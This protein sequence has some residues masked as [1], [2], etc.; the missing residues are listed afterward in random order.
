[1]FSIV[2]SF[3]FSFLF[4]Y[5]IV[6]LTV[7]CEYYGMIYLIVVCEYYKIIYLILVCRYN[8]LRNL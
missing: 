3:R 2:P 8:E 7:V 6:Y 1:M 4:F 5:T